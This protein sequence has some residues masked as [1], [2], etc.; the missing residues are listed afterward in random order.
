[1]HMS[2]SKNNLLDRFKKKMKLEFY[3]YTEGP[4]VYDDPEIQ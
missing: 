1:M 4:R 3:S 2:K